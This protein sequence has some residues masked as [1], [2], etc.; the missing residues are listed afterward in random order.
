MIQNKFHF[1]I[2]WK[3]AA[4]IIFEL[5]DKNEPFMWLKTW[6]NSPK[7]RIIK[8]DVSVAK[9]YLDEKEI[10]KLERTISSYFDYIENQIENKNTF[11]MQELANSVNKFLKFNDFEI[12]EW[13][14]K[15]SHKQA[16]EKAFWEYGEFNKTQKIESDFDREVKK[17]LQSQK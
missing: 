4:E 15:I 14:W 6:K 2:T 10:K 12:L 3:T 11:T 17:Y 8:T 5:V 16:E 9:N 7:W 13:K 1:A